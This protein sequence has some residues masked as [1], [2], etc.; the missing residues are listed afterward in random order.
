MFNSN[1]STNI[2]AVAGHTFIDLGQVM[3]GEVF[4]GLSTWFVYLSVWRMVTPKESLEVYEC[5]SN[6]LR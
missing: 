3:V 4:I 6:S 5:K 1:G 2:D